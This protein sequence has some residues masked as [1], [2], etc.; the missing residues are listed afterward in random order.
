MSK[1][2]GKRSKTGKPVK[3]SAPAVF[4]EDELNTTEELD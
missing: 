2:N 3:K 4:D 1:R